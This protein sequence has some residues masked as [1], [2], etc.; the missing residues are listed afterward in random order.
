MRFG[1]NGE[2]DTEGFYWSAEGAWYKSEGS[3]A[4][5]NS[6]HPTHW[7]DKSDVRYQVVDYSGRIVFDDCTYAEAKQFQLSVPKSMVL[8]VRKIGRAHV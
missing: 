8:P 7:A 4:R 2:R 6:V 5:R 3:K 1:D